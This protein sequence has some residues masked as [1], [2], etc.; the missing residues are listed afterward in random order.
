MV[1]ITVY[2][3]H[4]IIY[5]ISQPWKY[6]WK[7]TQNLLLYLTFP[8]TTMHMASFSLQYTQLCVLS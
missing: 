8:I 3:M 4:F 6:Y 7:M 5:E 2:E 1:M